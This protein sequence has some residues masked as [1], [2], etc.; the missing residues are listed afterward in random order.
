MTQ[1]EIYKL[2]KFSD[3]QTRIDTINQAKADGLVAYDPDVMLIRPVQD[4]GKPIDMV[5][6]KKYFQ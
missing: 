4:I 2:V 5:L 1:E 3:D 6:Y